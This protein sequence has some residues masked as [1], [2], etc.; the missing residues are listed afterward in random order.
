[1]QAGIA[2]V[3]AGALALARFVKAS[4][5][6]FLGAAR[7]RLTEEA[8]ECGALMRGPM[9][10]LGAICVAIGLAP[11]VVWPAIDRA[12]VAW[13]PNLAL[14]DSGVQLSSLGAMNVAIALAGCLGGFWLWRT[15]LA[16]GGRRGLTWDC[17]Y[18]APSAR[19]QY[20]SGSFSAIATSWFFW[21]LRPEL[22]I[23]RPRGPFPDEA[24]RM[25][26]IS[27][28]VM[29]RVILPNDGAVAQVATVPRRLQHRRAHAYI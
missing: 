29:E 10:F 5:V 12:V 13:S 25:P 21:L 2:L 16:N 17:G 22:K 24:H 14:S 1:M 26:E 9:L 7:T 15:V 18:A 23:R 4:S 8:H 19:M 20:T 27:Q 6:V 11:V 3:V 28:P